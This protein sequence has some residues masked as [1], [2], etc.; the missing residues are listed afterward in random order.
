MN[1]YKNIIFNII[2]LFQL[3][4]SFNNSEYVD[5]KYDLSNQIYCEILVNL[6]IDSNN[7]LNT[8]LIIDEYLNDSTFLA[9]INQNSFTPNDNSNVSKTL[10][11]NGSKLYTYSSLKDMGFWVPDTYSKQ[12]LIRYNQGIV[13]LSVL[14]STSTIIDKSAGIEMDTSEYLK[15]DDFE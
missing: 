4:C 8:H 15:A 1:F 14:D 7:H 5:V 9:T 6:G 11:C 13:K 12:L 10:V 3:G 2:L